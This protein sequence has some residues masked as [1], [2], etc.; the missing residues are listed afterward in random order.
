MNNYKEEKATQKVIN[1]K[2]RVFWTASKDK[3]LLNLIKSN[4]VKLNWKELTAN[5]N[6]SFKQCY[7]RYINIKPT[8]K[9]GAWTEAEEQKLKELLEIHGEKWSRISKEFGG[10]R[11]GKQ[12]RFHS[13]HLASMT[14]NKLSFTEED[15]QKLGQLYKEHGPEWQYISLYFKGRTA[16]NMKNR[17][18]NHKTQQNKCKSTKNNESEIISDI[19]DY[20]K[21]KEKEIITSQNISKTYETILPEVRN[22]EDKFDSFIEN[23]NMNDFKSVYDDKEAYD[24]FFN[25]TNTNLFAQDVY[26]DNTEG[27]NQ[28]NII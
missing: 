20:E 15:D 10:T 8:L 22:E 9:K 17:F 5:F 24:K 16:S 18:Y 3:L 11:S 7:D 23:R 25:D 28:N 14:S 27:N 4:G 2:K 1:K 6:M 19:E 12:I 21:E 13:K 26:F